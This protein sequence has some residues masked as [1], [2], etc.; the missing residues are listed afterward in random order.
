MGAETADSHK[1]SGK[2]PPE[3]EARERV[4]Y[5]K[6]Q[7]RLADNRVTARQ[8]RY[9]ACVR[10]CHQDIRDTVWI[11]QRFVS[12]Q[13]VLACVQGEKKGISAVTQA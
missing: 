8:A 13:I 3:A 2:G 7:K 12:T 9:I 1:P 4:A 11:L 10:V 5:E 6:K